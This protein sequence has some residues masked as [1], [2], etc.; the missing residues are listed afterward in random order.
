MKNACLVLAALLLG[1]GCGDSATTSSESTAPTVDTTGTWPTGD[2]ADHGFDPAALNAAADELAE[3]SSASLLVVHDGE[4][5]L[6]RYWNGHGQD[7][8]FP[9]FSV[10]KSF[11]STLVGRAEQLGHLSREDPAP[12]YIPEWVGTESEVL[13]VRH[14]MTNASG[15]TWDFAG[16]YPGSLGG[17][18]TPADLTDYAVDRGQQFPPETMWQYNQMAIQC[19]DRVLSAATGQTTES[20]ARA[21]LFDRLGMRGTRAGTDDVGQMTMAY[22][23]ESSARDLAR[24]GWLYLQEGRWNGEQLL[25]RDF[26]R[27]ATSTANPVNQNNGYLFWLNADRDWYE[28][29][30]LN[31][32]ETGKVYP[33]A[34]SDVFVASGFAGQL[35]LVSP[36]ERL[37]IVRQGSATTPGFA[38]HYDAI[39][40]RISEA[41]KAP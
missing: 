34:P 5:I 35:V 11:A 21:E 41:R 30:T 13:S 28:P 1:L 24:F 8:P 38:V 4:I 2:P 14:L 40:R 17:G 19:L 18:V 37:I 29:V 33:S 36:S 26:V 15:R 10:T 9:V 23:I 6:E 3:P 32:H 12:Q 16:D 7:Q 22:G 27:A 25:S 31:Y 39:Y 20:F